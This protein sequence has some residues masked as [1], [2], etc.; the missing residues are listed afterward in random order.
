MGIGINIPFDRAK[1]QPFVELTPE[2]RGDDLFLRIK[3]PD[4][5]AMLDSGLRDRLNKEGLLLGSTG[6]F[7]LRKVP[8]TPEGYINALLVFRPDKEGDGFN[9]RYW[10]KDIKV[11]GEGIEGNRPENSHIISGVVSPVRGQVRQ[12]VVG[13]Q[14][15]ISKKYLND[16]LLEGGFTI[17]GDP[18]QFRS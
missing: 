12:I 4:E 16:S 11:N 7:Y 9:N 1:G 2:I 10:A 5:L 17:E 15:S 3:N 6:E 8:T 18:K 13:G 14:G